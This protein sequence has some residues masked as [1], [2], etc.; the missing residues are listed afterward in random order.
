MFRTESGN[1]GFPYHTCATIDA[2]HRR[3]TTGM[4]AGDYFMICFVFSAYAI[5]PV[6]AGLLVRRINRSDLFNDKDE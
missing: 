6:L 2:P 4:N 1:Y 5:G 3:K